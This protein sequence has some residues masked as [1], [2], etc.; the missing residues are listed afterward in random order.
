MSGIH[1]TTLANGFQIVYEKS[2]STVPV[3]SIHIF[4]NIGSIHEP[5]DMKGVA[6]FI[7][8]MCFKGTR[9]NP[10]FRSILEKYT[11]FAVYYNGFT[12]KRYTYFV[13]KVIDEHLEECIGYLSEELLHSAFDLTEFRKE[14]KVVAE[15]NLGGNSNNSSIATEMMNELLYCDTVFQCPV[16][17][18][19]YHKK[20]FDYYRVVD[21]Y[22][23]NYIP[24]NMIFSIVTSTPFTKILGMV[25]R[26]H[27]NQPLVGKR[28]KS[29]HDSMHQEIY[30]AP[31]THGF[32]YHFK[33]RNI[34]V[35]YLR[36]GFNLSSQSNMKEMFAFKLLNTILSGS[37]G[38]LNLALRETKGLV[39]SVFTDTWHSESSGGIMIS[40]NFKPESFIR[41]LNIIIN[42]LKGLI[43]YG[44]DEK[45]LAMAK[46]NARG[47]FIADL[48]DIDGLAFHNGLWALHKKILP[49]SKMYDTFF[50][51][52]TME[53]MNDCIRR[54]FSLKQM[55]IAAIGNVPATNSI[56]SIC[57]KL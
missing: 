54:Y 21:L 33:Y 36:V 31:K 2:R 32:A 4:C 50:K 11:N 1:H 16:D 28:V 26:S 43:K 17:C 25:K 15:E 8:H 14:E 6:H 30:R 37:S 48:S 19:S 44:I 29:L 42:V 49:K 40:T 35:V 46:N 39:Y 20:T 45:E 7:E 5:K 3:S 12:N 55:R 27:F 51:N 34:G 22:K 23:Q 47:D 52:V 10:D 53:Y 41:V 18:T 57:R 38:K 13:L 24:S 56:L 9:D